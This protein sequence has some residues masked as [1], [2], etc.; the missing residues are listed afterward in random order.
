MHRFLIFFVPLLFPLCLQAQG[1]NRYMVFFSDKENN[2]WSLEQPEAFLSPRAL[3][4]RSKQ[5]ILLSEEDLP[6]SEAYVE[7]VKS[8]GG[9]VFY[10]SRWFNAALIEANAADLKRIELLPKV[11]SVVFVAPGTKLSDGQSQRKKRSL[12]L[13]AQLSPPENHQNTI[14]GVPQM[15]AKGFTGEGKLIAILDG[16]FL[17]VDELPYFSHF[18]DEGKLIGQ[19]DFTTSSTDVFR[20]STHG[21][22]ALSTIAA[23]DSANFIGTAPMAEFLLAVTEDVSS[24]YLIEEYNWLLGAEWADSAGTDVITASLGYNTFD[25][26]AMNY[27]YR[28]LD[29]NTT[30]SAR[31]ATMAAERGI[32][33]VVSAG[34]SGSSAWKYIVTPADAKGIISV[35]AIREGGEIASFSSRGPTADGRIKPEVV[36]I[37]YKT[38]VANENGGFTAGNGT[39]YAAPQI[40]GFAAAAWAAFPQLSSKE[41]RELILSSG[42]KAANPDTVFGWGKP[43]FPLMEGELLAIEKIRSRDNI[44]IYPNPVQEGHLFLEFSE[45]PAVDTYIKLYTPAGLT[46]IEN[47]K[48]TPLR[49]GEK[50]FVVD[51]LNIPKGFYILEVINNGKISPFKIIRY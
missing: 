10:R 40:A 18:F 6:V 17:A 12:R 31:A 48:V 29:G 27:S 14:L 37:G 38:T 39:S 51:L 25:D 47:R 30:V 41:L 32:V 11:D 46:F 19:H 33:V 34:N 3:E 16:G 4:R 26:P 13:S 9:K 21:T 7:E 36:A 49:S 23:I 35:G 15:Q 22:K 43:F 24:E 8:A 45:Q 42:S 50:T 28:D 20:Y 5:G 1:T 2:T 44:K